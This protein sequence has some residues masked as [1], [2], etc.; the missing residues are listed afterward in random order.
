MV[1]STPPTLLLATANPGKRRE[2]AA[3]L[4]RQIRLLTLDDLLIQLPPETG[5]TFAENASAKAEFAAS[6]SGLLTLA[7]DSGLEVDALGGEPG[8]R[9]ARYA[10]E[11]PN[12]EANRRKLLA[13]LVGVPQ[14]QRSARFQCAV[15]I[16]SP[17]GVVV[18]GYG[19]CV[20]SIGSAPVGAHGF[21]Y[22]P[23]FV[24]PD[25]RTMAELTQGEKNQVSHR[26]AAYRAVLPSLTRHL[27]GD[28]ED[29]RR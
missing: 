29:D 4:P 16:A 9:S 24:L 17:A 13:A 28:V 3:L 15:A 11:P 2:L 20:G 1:E 6:R 10:G 7:D 18:T 12:D 26:A 19:S 27:S 22:D 21:G 23:I 5:P 25:G 8:V 14:E